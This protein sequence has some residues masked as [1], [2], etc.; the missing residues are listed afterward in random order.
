MKKPQISIMFDFALL[1]QLAMSEAGKLYPFENC[2][3]VSEIVFDEASDY[4]IGIRV[5]EESEVEED[6]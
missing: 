3:L 5:W 1:H 6:S 4:P 2:N